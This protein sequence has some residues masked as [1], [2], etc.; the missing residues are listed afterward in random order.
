MSD[1][2]N[3]ANQ[4]FRNLQNNVYPGRGII[5][6]RDRFGEIVQVYWI[7]GRSPNSRNRIF[8]NDGDGTVRT[9]AAD[10]SKV[11]DSSLIIYPA[12][13]EI[14]DRRVYGVS[15]GSQ[16]RDVV[17]RYLGCLF[18]ALKRWEYEPDAPNF[19]PR[20]SALYDARDTRDL[21]EIMILAKSKYSDACTRHAYRYTYLDKSI[22]YC[23]T[24]Y[25][26]DG[27]PL[28]AFSGEPYP[29]PLGQG[30]PKAIALSYWEALNEENRVSLVVK[31]ITPDNGKSEIYI[32]NQYSQVAAAG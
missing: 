26:G 3:I 8:V 11:E 14:R 10:P 6:G 32:K 15:N 28:P 13:E 18:E 4:N 17:H 23:V 16:T 29:M 21:I 19:T 7:M 27:S 22:G 30:D 5:I 24:T 9:E 2:M 12:M 20:I 31:R 25:E 1:L